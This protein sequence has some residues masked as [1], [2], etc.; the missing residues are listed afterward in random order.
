MKPHPDI[1]PSTNP[2][3]YERWLDGIVRLAEGAR[4]RKVSPDTLRR[5]ARRGRV[6]LLQLSERAVGIRRRHALMMK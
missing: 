4:L 3:E 2:I 5:E 6:Q 1:S